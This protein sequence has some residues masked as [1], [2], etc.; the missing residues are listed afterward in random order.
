MIA[1]YFS[2]VQGNDF[3]RKTKIVKN[4]IHI[5]K[6]NEEDLKKYSRWLTIF[7]GDFQLLLLT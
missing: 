2:S 7:K 3:T 6:R 5:L 1:T 4:V